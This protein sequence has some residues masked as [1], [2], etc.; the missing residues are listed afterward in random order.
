MNRIALY[1]RLVVLLGFIT[2]FG[3]Q[4][5]VGYAQEPTPP[6]RPTMS[7]SGAVGIPASFQLPPGTLPA[8][9]SAAAQ[10]AD[11]WTADIAEDF[12]IGL[13]SWV[14]FDNNDDG[15]DRRWGID[16]YYANSGTQSVWVAAGGAD[17]LDP[18]QYYYPNDLAT[19]LVYNQP[20]DLTN[21]QAAD[22][23]FYM[24]M[25]IEPDYDF[26]FAGVS[27]DGVNF[28]GD[29]WTG[30]S[31]GW[32]WHSIDLSA[33]IGEP[34][35]YIAWYFYSDESNP[36]NYEGVWID[37]VTVWT[38]VDTG[39]AA[40]DDAVDN[41][42]FETG[43]LTGWTVPNGSTVITT[44]AENPLSGQHVAYFG[45]IDN[46]EEIFYQSLLIPSAA[47][48]ARVSFYA[49]SFGEETVEGADFFCAGLYS[50][51]MSDLV[52]DLGCIDG[53]EVFGP[54][55]DPDGWWQM[56]YAINGAQWETIKGRTLNLAFEMYTNESSPT[57]VFIDD[58]VFATS[59]GGAPSDGNDS[60]STAKPA[61]LGQEMADLSINPDQDQDFY[62][63]TANAGDTIA[64]DI[65][66]ADS[67]SSLDSYVQI[68]DPD[69]NVI[70]ENDD[71]GDSYDSYVSCAT[72]R[73]GIHY[74]LVRSYSGAGDRSFTYSLLI[75]VSGGV[76]P[77]PT[78][79][80]VPSVTPPP[81]AGDK[82][83]WTAII[84]IDGDNNLCDSYPGLITRMEQELGSRIGANG[85][86]NVAVLF[87]RD[88]RYCSGGGTTRLL[89]Q[90]NGAYQDNVNRWD[91]GEVNMGD[92]LTLVNFAKW[93]MT[94]YPADHYYLAIDNHGGGT[95]GIAWDDSNSHDNI[96][97]DELY[98]ALKDITNNGQTP[99]DVFAYEACLMGMYEN[100]YDARQ[101]TKYLFFFPT[102]SWTNSAS[103]PAYLGDS[104]FSASSDGRA[105]GEI[106]FDVYYNAVRS[107]YSVSLVDS[108][109]LGA[110]HTA[111]TNW[112]NLLRSQNANQIPTMQA[113]RAAAQKIDQDGN[114]RLDENDAYIDL[115]DLADQ[116]A[117]RGI[118]ANEAT[119]VKAAVD[120]AVLLTNYRP[121][122][123]NTPV[124]YSKQHGLSIYWPRTTSG[125][126]N[127]YINH[128]IYNSTRDGTWDEFLRVYF[129]DEGARNVM[130]TS[131]GAI[132]R[133]PTDTIQIFLPSVV[134]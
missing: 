123:A 64:A 86:L 35:V 25:D 54:Q 103:Y 11:D 72:G 48:S 95:S 116:M 51:D 110:L 36:G 44:Q 113:A 10:S 46:A 88:P 49:N 30:N 24:N 22:V 129:G 31:G 97:N 91:M 29:Y 14:V 78:T 50:Q 39:P 109:K 53:V 107:P 27:T 23:E 65:N 58:V 32:N 6:Q 69:G 12:E 94:N 125:D 56:D 100:A 59:S 105:L 90:P 55:F 127:G 70:C 68:L 81:P 45:G 89:I 104:R 52:L 120:D 5:S 99:I 57:T 37:G 33:Y 9:T 18:E 3:F 63:F 108:S 15:V 101:F 80:P 28:Y 82:R 112:A 40:V 118:G 1:I 130:N 84:Y 47:T 62:S 102:I 75:Q 98:S 77:T 73:S 96:T 61:T 38:Y 131:Y 119:A 121:A 42:D 83:S 93:A 71:D 34:Q 21:A 126:Y 20:L 41:G 19:W 128:Q 17:A 132:D 7:T 111:M 8:V 76:I 87:D 43:D 2:G 16:D 79:T 74:V 4:G 13:S 114:N 85:F 133:R 66:A 26:I 60:M 122:T 67:G 92:P 134:R 115:W 117:V 124:D 106:I